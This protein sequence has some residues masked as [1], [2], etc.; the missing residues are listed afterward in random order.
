MAFKIS[1]IGAGYMTTE[2]LKAFKDIHDVEFEGIYSK[3]KSKAVEV[4]KQY[5]IKNV[6]DNIDDLYTSTNS[7][8]VIIS[9]PELSLREVCEVVFKYPWT[10]LIEKPV[11]YNLNDAE[12]ILN[13]AKKNNA[14]VYSDNYYAI[15]IP[16]SKPYRRISLYNCYWN[17]PQ[18]RICCSDIH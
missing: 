14:K 10:S 8:A 13:L 15:Q 7:D 4:S 5:G 16:F 2:H 9:V 1:F 17:V 3:T 11:G 12:Y 6:F 18:C